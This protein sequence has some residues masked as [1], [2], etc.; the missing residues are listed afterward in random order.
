MGYRVLMKN[1]IKV[2]LRSRVALFCIFFFPFIAPMILNVNFVQER[3]DRGDGY[4]LQVHII[5]QASTPLSRELIHYL[6]ESK[7]LNVTIYSGQP[8]SLEEAKVYYEQDVNYGYITYLYL[9]KDFDEKLLSEKKGKALYF[10]QPGEDEREKLVE[11][12]IKLFLQE[13]RELKQEGIKTFF[14]ETLEARHQQKQAVL[15]QGTFLYVDREGESSVP[16][17]SYSFSFNMFVS[18]MMI[19]FSLATLMGF[20][21]I[22][23]E[24]ENGVLRRLLLTPI[25]VPHY[26]LS[27][28][29]V[30]MGLIGVQF[31]IMGLGIV[32]WVKIP[33]NL[34][35]WQITWLVSLLGV[36]LATFTLWLEIR[37]KPNQAIEYGFCL[38][39]MCSNLISGLSFS[40]DTAPSWMQNIAILFPQ[41]WV[42]Y[43]VENLVLKKPYAMAIYGGVMLI[44][45]LFFVLLTSVTLYFKQEEVEE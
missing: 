6:E 11:R 17:I 25:T 44:F 4:T 42:T 43:T 31:F 14:V 40:I 23:K 26:L 41:R 32:C 20:G 30:V 18:I 36:V 45:A 8:L 1:H 38:L 27:R 5:D 34:S 3:K 16:H 33:L 9:E 22:H 12:R 29:L 21:V 15:P 37:R 10:Y 13:V 7:N 24:R 39:L 35:I 2:L 19:N 28:T